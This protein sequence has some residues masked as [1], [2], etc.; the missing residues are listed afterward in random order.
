MKKKHGM[1]IQGLVTIRQGDRVIVRDIPNHFV[2]NGLKGLISQIINAGHDSGGS[3][4]YHYLWENGWNMYLGSDTTTVTTTTMTALVSP[5]GTAPGTSPNSK[6]GSLKDGSTDGV[7]NGVFLAT[8]NSG[9]VSGTCGEL[10]LYGKPPTNQ[11]AF[12]WR[13]TYTYNP[14]A[15]MFSRLAS[16]DADFSSFVINTDVPLTVEWKVQCS[17]V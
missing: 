6:S 3:H 4:T 7:W 5:I 16:A 17:F 2:D 1:L 8:W 9:T 13:P 12:G 11:T 14:T 10:G 15:A